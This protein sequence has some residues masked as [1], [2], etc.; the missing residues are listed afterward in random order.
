MKLL[1]RKIIGTAVVTEAGKPTVD[2]DIEVLGHALNER[3]RALY[4]RSL[5]IREGDPGSCNGCELEIGGLNSAYYDL[6]RFQLHF[7]PYPRPADF[8]LVPGAVSRHIEDPF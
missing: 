7:V 6:E 4:G 1:F 8:L 3:V 2:A 5:H